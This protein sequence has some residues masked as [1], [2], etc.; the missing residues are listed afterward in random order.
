MP[1]IVQNLSVGARVW[2][3]VQEVT[4]K[5]LVISLP[6]GLRAFV[7]PEDASDVLHSLTT[8]EPSKD[9]KRLRKVVRGAAPTLPDL[10]YPGQFVRGVI[11]R[12]E[13]AHEVPDKSPA[14]VRSLPEACLVAAFFVLCGTLTHTVASTAFH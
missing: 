13:D 8:P 1:G 2:G 14:A 12:L 10:F 5:R 3:A 11:S 9:D 4:L 6:H 7:A